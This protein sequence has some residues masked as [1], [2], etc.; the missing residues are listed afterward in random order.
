M[1]ACERC[2]EEVQGAFYEEA[3][4]SDIR[5]RQVEGSKKDKRDLPAAGY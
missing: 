3:P 2:L 5:L 1:G 4:I